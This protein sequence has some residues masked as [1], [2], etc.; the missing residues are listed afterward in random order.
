MSAEKLL[1]SIAEE[2]PVLMAKIAAALKMTETIDQDFAEDTAREFSV[3]LEYTTE[4]VAA[5]WADWGKGVAAMS[6]V[7]LAGA[8]G[9]DLYDAAKRGL[10]ASANF[11]R[12][13]S[14][15]EAL[16][17]YDKK[18][19]R[20][21]F[22]SLH[23]YA[24]EFT[25]DPSVG[26]QLIH[27]MLEVPNDQHNIIKDFVMARKNLRESKQRQFQMNNVPY[28]APDNLA[29][30]HEWAMKADAHKREQDILADMA[31]QNY[32]QKNKK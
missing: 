26:G 1:Q 10:T 31:G 30:K 24:P 3:I 21:A 18:D 22:D 6:A 5:G 12:I 23:R 8:V 4:K 7:S 20:R 2:Q 17:G 29:E 15:N 25:A 11:R 32:L 13:M 9:S 19:V 14:G 16:A 27:R 28:Q